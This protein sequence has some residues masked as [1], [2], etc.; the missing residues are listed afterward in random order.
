MAGKGLLFFTH[1]LKAGGTSVEAALRRA[2]G[3]RHMA[4]DPPTGWIYTLADFRRDRRLNP[5]ARSYA[6]HWLRPFVDF[7]DFTPRIVWHTMLREPVDRYRS[8][9]QHH[10]ERLGVRS[11]FEEWSSDPILRNWQVRQIAGEDDVDAAIQI[12]EE[13]YRFVGLLERFAESIVLMRDRLAV[14]ALSLE[15]DPVHNA[16]RS[17]RV[18][19]QVDAE[20]ERHAQTV[21]DLNAGDLRLYRHVQDHLYARQVDEYG[22]ARLEADVKRAKQRR[23]SLAALLRSNSH[24]LFRRF[25]HIPIQRRRAAAAAREGREDVRR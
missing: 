19:E 18:K 21:Q 25:C 11:S 7:G 4:V 24:L 6:S 14:P 2:L 5:F 15:P 10:V 22:A 9:R 17:N 23:D 8:H 12:L 1:V 16:A 20:M 13:R 3:V